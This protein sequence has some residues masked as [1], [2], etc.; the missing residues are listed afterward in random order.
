MTGVAVAAAQRGQ[1]GRE[2]DGPRRHERASDALAVSCHRTIVRR[3]RGEV[4][5]TGPDGS[6]QAVGPEGP[7]RRWEGTPV[8][9]A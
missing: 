2:S 3:A 8:P 4:A 1:G 7:S 6:E 5:E 9:G